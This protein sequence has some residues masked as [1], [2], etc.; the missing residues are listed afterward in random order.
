MALDE[1]VHSGI[2]TIDVAIIVAS[3][4]NGEPTDNAR[5]FLT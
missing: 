4:Y 1:F 3:T 5:E 2:K